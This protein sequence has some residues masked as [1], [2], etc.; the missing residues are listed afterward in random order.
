VTRAL[1]LSTPSLAALPQAWMEG[2]LDR[3][4]NPRQV[5][6]CRMSLLALPFQPLT[7]PQRHTQQ[8]QH[9]VLRRSAGLASGF[10]AI[11]G[12]EPQHSPPALLPRLM[13][14]LLRLVRPTSLLCIT[15]SRGWI[16]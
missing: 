16:D 3:L 2:L 11:V 8:P 4:R 10:L 12:A 5:N 7:P 1:L 15:H 6:K 14:E 13:G 9:F